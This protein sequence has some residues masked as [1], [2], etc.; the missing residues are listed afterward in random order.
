MRHCR[1]TRLAYDSCV[2]YLLDSPG[3]TDG[4]AV[5]DS[6]TH[7]RTAITISV[8]FGILWLSWILPLGY[9]LWSYYW[10]AQRRKP[11]STSLPNKQV[12]GKHG[13]TRICY[14][15]N[16]YMPARTYHCGPMRKCLP[17]Y[18]HF[19]PWWMGG[20]W[21]HNLKA[22]LTF[23][24]FL[25]LYHAFVFGVGMWVAVDKDRRSHVKVLMGTGIVCGL[26]F[27]LSLGIMIGMWERLVFRLSL[28]AEDENPC[29]LVD[30]EG[31][32]QESKDPWSQGWR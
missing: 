16:I 32:P 4:T 13:E 31:V 28:E 7:L 10:V 3:F 14:V 30:D 26:A 18:D 25:P 23:L 8:I 15:C 19:C 24:A 11:V 21:V 20:V 2:K 1:S 17:H 12:D 9:C 27:L 5:Q 22:Y 6:K 29:F